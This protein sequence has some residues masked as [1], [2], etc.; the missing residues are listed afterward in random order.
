[1]VIDRYRKMT[2]FAIFIALF[3]IAGCS[4]QDPY[5]DD[6]TALIKTSEG[7]I[8]LVLYEEESPNTVDNFM[9]YVEEGFYNGTVFHRVID[10]FMI[11][12]GGFTPDGEQKTTREPIEYEGDN[13]LKNKEG[14][15]AMART[16]DPDSATSQFFIN[17]EDNE[18]LDH[19]YGNV[20][21]TVF[22][23]VI[24]DMDVVRDIGSSETG[25]R[26]GMAD[27]PDDD[28]IIEGIEFS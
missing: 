27:W 25:F 24:D 12:G 26:Y 10:G 6:T 21:Y 13:G 20:G 23:K 19:G 18:Q 14:K 16:S 7:D 8:R 1:M 5:A 22:G 3:I 11:Q 2:F 4:Y 17:L 9:E 15:I 28:I